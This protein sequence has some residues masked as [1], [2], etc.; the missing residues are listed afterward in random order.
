M[1]EYKCLPSPITVPPCPSGT[2]PVIEIEVN[3]SD[4]V[5]DESSFSH[6]AQ[7]DL[8]VFLALV[9]SLFIGFLAG[10]K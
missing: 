8:I 1:N 3:G 5:R 10:K 6:V 2:A 9:F 7:Q 4:F